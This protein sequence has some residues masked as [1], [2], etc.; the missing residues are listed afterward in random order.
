MRKAIESSKKGPT[1]IE[2]TMISIPAIL[3]LVLSLGYSSVNVDAVR[4]GASS[5]LNRANSRFT[6]L[7]HQDFTTRYRVAHERSD[8]YKSNVNLTLEKVGETIKELYQ[9]LPRVPMSDRRRN[10]V[11]DR[12]KMI[13]DMD[14]NN[15]NCKSKD[16][17][18]ISLVIEQNKAYKR[19][20]VRYIDS[21]A[22]KHMGRC[23]ET[24]RNAILNK[25][26]LSENL[27]I[28]TPSNQGDVWIR[29]RNK[30]VSSWD[31]NLAENS[32]D[33]RFFALLDTVLAKYAAKIPDPPVTSGTITFN[34]GKSSPTPPLPPTH[35]RKALKKPPSLDNQRNK[36]FKHSFSDMPTRSSSAPCLSTI[37]EIESSDSVEGSSLGSTIDDS[38]TGGGSVQDS[39]QGSSTQG[40]SY[41][42]RSSQSGDSSQGSAVC[43]ID[44]AMVR[45]TKSFDGLISRIERDR[46]EGEG[47]GEVGLMDDFVTNKIS[48]KKRRPYFFIPQDVIIEGAVEFA[49]ER[50]RKGPFPGVAISTPG[51]FMN[52][53][54]EELIVPC[55]FILTGEDDYKAAFELVIR[56]LQKNK[57]ILDHQFAQIM[58]GLKVC[59][60][61]QYVDKDRH[62]DLLFGILK[63]SKNLFDRMALGL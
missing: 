18:R 36:R 40:S 43:R 33:S 39:S 41:K 51:K 6:I 30:A 52:F 16:I 27:G 44:R 62:K 57:K 60:R 37:G 46:A 54:F 38:S 58:A 26:R 31:E 42:R 8:K 5:A 24:I 11:K 56:A 20:L 48:S 35:K 4:V 53:F 13:I 28:L 15:I 25:V 49:A 19:F 23:K 50:F 29:N 10:F 47:E 32:R 22:D 17:R 45:S 7:G 34:L 2:R 1:D 61:L 3:I 55:R 63:N 12:L 9:Y 14:S 21:L 59:E